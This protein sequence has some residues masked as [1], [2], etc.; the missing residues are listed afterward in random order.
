MKS[1]IYFDYDDTLGGVEVEGK[2][3]TI[4]SAY[5]ILIDELCEYMKELGY[6]P[7]VARYI[8]AKTASALHVQ[9][10]F[11][12][13][14]IFPRSFAET[15]REV[16]TT[17]GHRVDSVVSKKCERLA[18]KIYSEFPYV[19]MPGAEELLERVSKRYNIAIVTKG[20]SLEQE[21]KMLNTGVREY[22]DYTKVVEYKNEA[23]WC[24][25]FK[26]TGLF[27]R[28]SAWSIGNSIKSDINIPLSYG[29]NAI[30]IVNTRWE[31]EHQTYKTPKVGRMLKTVS[32]IEEVLN[33]F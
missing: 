32:S 7:E 13:K 28:A 6:D 8:Q 21:I 17:Q 11:S 25:V 31:F 3:T 19:L 16:A 29:L 18:W 33:F 5:Y 26:D 30:H 12:D 4:E 14:R 15:Y 2:P 9:Y 1:W 20:D 10:G 22:A 23:D 27:T 24:G